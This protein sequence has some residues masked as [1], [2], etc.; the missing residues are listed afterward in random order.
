MHALNVVLRD[1]QLWSA[2]TEPLLVTSALQA[3]VIPVVVFYFTVRVGA[4]VLHA[5]ECLP[6]MSEMSSLTSL[7][8]KPVQGQV[9][10]M[11]CR[12]DRLFGGGSAKGTTIL[13]V[14]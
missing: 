11:S 5:L 2:Y 7:S 8:M 6:C 9:W 10:L 4:R 13:A 12:R 3:V 1:H 14:S